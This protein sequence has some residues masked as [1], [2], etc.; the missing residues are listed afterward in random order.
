MREN[1]ES[2]NVNVNNVCEDFNNAQL[3]KSILC[4]VSRCSQTNPASA[5]TVGY[6]RP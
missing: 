5:F 1:N 2:I 6:D 4:D 3:L